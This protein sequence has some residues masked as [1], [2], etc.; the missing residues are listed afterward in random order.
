[1]KAVCMK[2]DTVGALATQ[3]LA[4]EPDTR[5][6]IDLEREMHKDYEKEVYETIGRGRKVYPGNF[7]VVVITKKERLL[8]N[9][10]RNY[11]FHRETCPT[12]D[13][14]QTVYYI[15]QPEEKIDFLW[16]IP[17]RD[18][19]F[20]LLENERF[21]PD[22]ERQLLDFIKDFKSSKLFEL[23]KRLNNEGNNDV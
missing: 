8:A 2:R 6:P 10:L 3:L 1:M 19:C 21:L 9:V 23:S 18:T 14:D 7:Y 11:F 17:S 12:P 5:N 13:Y 20:Y 4:K 15:Q 22:N 16:V